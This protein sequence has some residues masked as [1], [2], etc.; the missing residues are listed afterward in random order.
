MSG[1]WLED[2]TWPEAKARFDAPRL[3][4]FQHSAHQ[5]PAFVSDPAPPATNDSAGKGAISS[6]AA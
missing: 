6:A 3:Q 2:L 4:L 1:I 5:R